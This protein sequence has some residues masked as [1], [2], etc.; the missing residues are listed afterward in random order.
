M[1][2]GT[3]APD[4]FET[5]WPIGFVKPLCPNAGAGGADDPLLNYSNMN[6]GFTIRFPNR[7]STPTPP[8]SQDPKKV[9][10]KI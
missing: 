6:L 2:Q 8:Q 4:H 5:L 7:G 9:P 1:F 10:P 3:V